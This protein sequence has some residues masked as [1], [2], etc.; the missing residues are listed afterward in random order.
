MKFELYLNLAL[1]WTVNQKE[2]IG[3]RPHKYG[4]MLIKHA[5]QM[6]K[7]RRHKKTSLWNGRIRTNIV[8]KTEACKCGSK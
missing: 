7:K 3:L 8:K 6:V 4:G 5:T 2:F 1:Y